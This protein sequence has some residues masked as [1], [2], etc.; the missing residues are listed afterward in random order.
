MP[1]KREVWE[2]TRIVKDGENATEKQNYYTATV[3]WK[4]VGDASDE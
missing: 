2:G 4:A 3:T 1:V